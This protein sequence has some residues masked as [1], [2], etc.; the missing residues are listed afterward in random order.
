M[1]SV[2]AES[3]PPPASLVPLP[4]PGRISASPKTADALAS[5]SDDTAKLTPR[6]NTSH[7]ASDTSPPM[8]PATSAPRQP[9][10][11]AR[12]GMAKGIRMVPALATNVE[13][14][15][16]RLRRSGSNRVATV[17]M[18]SGVCTASVTPRP[19]RAA[20]T[21]AVE[22]AQPWA[23]AAALHAVAPSCIERLTP[24]RSTIQPVKR[25]AKA[26]E[27]CVTAARS[28]KSLSVQPKSAIMSGLR[29]AMIGRSMAL[30]TPARHKVANSAQ[31]R[32]GDMWCIGAIVLLPRFDGN[33]NMALQGFAGDKV[34]PHGFTGPGLRLSIRSH[35][36]PIPCEGRCQRRFCHVGHDPISG[37]VGVD[38][39]A[40]QAVAR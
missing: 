39:V 34:S 31:R 27:N 23:M 6:A 16:A 25:K 8:P 37:G 24:I 15:N 36:P 29:M 20:T 7:S 9:K 5:S 3:A 32:R 22:M 13:T 38:A 12:K 26:A 35:R 1:G 30:N 33:S 18:V 40:G 2:C 17:L 28:P 10:V 21:C 4:V 19:T 11:K 14:P